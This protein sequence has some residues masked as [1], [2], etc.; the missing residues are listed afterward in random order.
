MPCVASRASALA[1]SEG[2]ASWSFSRLRGHAAR[3]SRNPGLR[4]HELTRRVTRPWRNR[5]FPNSRS[6]GVFSCLQSGVET[7]KQLVPCGEL[8][9]QDRQHSQ[10][11]ERGC[12]LSQEGIPGPFTPVKELGVLEVSEAQERHGC[13]RPQV[14]RVDIRQGVHD[15]EGDPRLSE[16]PLSPRST[17]A[18][19]ILP[20]LEVIDLASQAPGMLD[21]PHDLARHHEFVLPRVL[22][23]GRRD[24]HQ[25]K[26]PNRFRE[27]LTHAGEGAPGQA[28]R[29][30]SQ[31][32]HVLRSW[33]SP[34]DAAL[35]PGPPDQRN[36]PSGS[37]HP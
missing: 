9:I 10:D 29:G 21:E 31:V 18:E 1:V 26:L 3:R 6:I 5:Y 27:A 14:I 19:G 4:Q 25:F 8:H 22:N 37:G 2:S 23:P 24:V 13:H 11:L 36:G 28:A 33:R 35:D 20:G 17:S 16:D 32:Q 30:S 15:P 12:S 34:A 7:L